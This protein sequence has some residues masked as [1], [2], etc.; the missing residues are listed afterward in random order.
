MN[1][2]DRVR[3]LNRKE[4][5]IIHRVHSDGTATVELASGF[6]TRELQRNLVT[7]AVEERIA[8][9][10]PAVADKNAPARA[11]AIIGVYV[12]FVH[13][14]KEEY[15]YYV[16]NNT[17]LD[18][19]VTLGMKG[20]GKYQG[21]FAGHIPA[22]TYKRNEQM[23]ANQ[24]KKMPDLHVRAIYHQQGDGKL[25]DMLDVAVKVSAGELSVRKNV[26]AP[27]LDR[28]AY[29]WQIDTD[30]TKLPETFPEVLKEYLTGSK[31]AI[32]PVEFRHL[33]PPDIV[34]LHIEKL[35]TQIAGLDGAT[36]LNKQLQAFHFALDNAL[37][38]GK[39]SITFIHGVGAGILK[40]EILK[41]LS[42]HKK[43]KFFKEADPKMFGFGATVVHLG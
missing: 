34:D 9:R 5:G 13:V 28:E 35:M 36:M 1:I 6:T 40:S 18:I 22:R 16:V 12:A 2:G 8:F 27:L 24:L 26:K 21:I 42:T 25:F 30:Y 33:M 10:G 7:I 15:H 39:P 3:L 37:A 32:K 43:V 14:G 20:I 31:R 4:E 17:D 19:L 41:V 23:H 38:L 11:I 29:I